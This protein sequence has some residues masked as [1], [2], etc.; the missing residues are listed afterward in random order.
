MAQ[1]AATRPLELVPTSPTLRTPS[2][3]EAK[4]DGDTIS[5]HAPDG[6]LL[7]HYD[8]ATGALRLSARTEV[9][10]SAKGGRLSLDAE[11]LEIAATTARVKVKDWHFEAERILERTFDAFRTVEGI[12]ETHA[13]RM[14]TIVDRTLELCSR[15][16]TVTSKEDTRIDGKRVLLG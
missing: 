6:A 16:T 8:A 13:R 15:R 3:A 14:R 12:A 5:I 11:T 2:G 7:A 10:V 4:T 1:P 9:V